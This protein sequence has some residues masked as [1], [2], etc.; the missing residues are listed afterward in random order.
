MIL[1]IVGSE[2]AKFTV[3]TEAKAREIIRGLLENLPPLSASCSGECHLGGIDLWTREES[4]K[5]EIPFIPYPPKV[6]EWE[7]GYKPRNIKIAKTSDKVVCITLRE[8]PDSY[9]GMRFSRCYH[10]DT[11]KHVKSGGCWTAKYAQ[12]LGKEIEIIVIG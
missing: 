7:R 9:E 2:G 1:G 10:C 4:E 3:E 12:G 5:L 11:D 8:L 6:L